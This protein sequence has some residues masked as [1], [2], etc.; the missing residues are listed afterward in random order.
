M[1]MSHDWFQLARVALEAAV[2][3]SDD[4]D[5]LAGHAKPKASPVKAV[6]EIALA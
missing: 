5:L 6:E 3:G 4:L 2:R 1:A